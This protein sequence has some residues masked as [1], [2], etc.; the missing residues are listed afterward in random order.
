MGQCEPTVRARA[1]PASIKVGLCSRTL[2]VAY[3]VRCTEYTCTPIP[4]SSCALPLTN[5]NACSC[6]EVTLVSSVCRRG[7]RR[8][9][10]PLRAHLHTLLLTSTAN[11]T[12]GTSNK[13]SNVSSRCP[14]LRPT[15]AR[16]PYR[17]VC[18]PTRLRSHDWAKDSSECQA[19]PS[20]RAR[21]LSERQPRQIIGKNISL[22]RPKLV[23]A[24][25]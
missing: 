11:S 13:A 15:D 24:V 8:R 14:T 16:K 21:T 17:V 5:E 2:A 22:Q 18:L 6:Q 25:L 12:E 7:S 4:L 9:Y 23:L 3:G 1:S 19:R 20:Q 10:V